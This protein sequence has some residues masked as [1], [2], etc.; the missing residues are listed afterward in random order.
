M[1]HPS[2]RKRYTCRKSYQWWCH[3]KNSAEKSEKD[4]SSRQTEKPRGFWTPLTFFFRVAARKKAA[5][6]TQFTTPAREQ[7]NSPLTHLER[8]F[9]EFGIDAEMHLKLTPP[10]F[11]LGPWNQWWWYP[12]TLLTLLCENSCLFIRCIYDAMQCKKRRKY[13]SHVQ[14]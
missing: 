2:L 5:S 12:C 9:Y 14:L 11:G 4:P 7:N 8:Y 1:R 6:I 13:S 10:L 3:H